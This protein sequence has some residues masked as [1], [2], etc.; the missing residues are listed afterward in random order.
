[1]KYSDKNSKIEISIE[2]S[3]LTIKDYGIGIDE[4]ELSMIYQRYYQSD[5]KFIG[6]GIGLSIVKRYCD[7]EGIGLKIESKKG[8]GT[9]VELDFRRVLK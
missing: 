2:G 4:N 3:K 5:N 6:S 7:S 8:K 9:S 1:M